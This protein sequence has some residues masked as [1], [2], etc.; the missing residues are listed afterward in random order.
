VHPD[1]RHTLRVTVFIEFVRDVFSR[2]SHEL[3]GSGM[4]KLVID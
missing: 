1:L 4:S 3:I 2:R